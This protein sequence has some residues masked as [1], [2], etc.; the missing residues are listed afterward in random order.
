MS[1]DDMAGRSEWHSEIRRKAHRRHEKKSR[2]HFL[3][4][5]AQKH[6]LRIF[7]FSCAFLPFFR[8]VAKLLI[9]RAV[10]GIF[11]GRVRRRG[12]KQVKLSHQIPR[13]CSRKTET[14]KVPSMMNFPSQQWKPKRTKKKAWTH[15]HMHEVQ[16]HQN[17]NN[18]LCVSCPFQY[19]T[20]DDVFLY[21]CNNKPQ[22]KFASDRMDVEKN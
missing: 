10:C 20:C 13:I 19:Y 16:W 14:Q 5:P 11:K 4:H 2:K 22:S 7:L 21:C 3:A 1:V 9:I 12:A 15:F 18:V 17:I 8:V 6:I